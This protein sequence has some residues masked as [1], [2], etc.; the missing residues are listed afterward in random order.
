[1]PKEVNSSETGDA[2]DRHRGNFVAL[3]H[4]PIYF[5]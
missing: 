1:M 3:Y 4:H 5:G 2:V